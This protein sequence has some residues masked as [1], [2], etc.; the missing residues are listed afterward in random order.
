MSERKRRWA[1]R[2]YVPL[3][4][5]DRWAGCGEDHQPRRVAIECN[6]FH[7]LPTPAMRAWIEAEERA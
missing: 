4:F 2:N 5:L 1:L 6:L 7:G 3:R